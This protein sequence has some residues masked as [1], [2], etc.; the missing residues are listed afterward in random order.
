MSSIT[1]GAHSRPTPNRWN[2]T[3][4]TLASW[5]TAAA[6]SAAS[7]AGHVSSLRQVTLTVTGLGLVDAA[8]YQTTTGVGLLVTGASLLVLEW[9]TSD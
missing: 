2:Q 1:V 6:R 8:A 9:L 3:R 7:I 5:R 4:K